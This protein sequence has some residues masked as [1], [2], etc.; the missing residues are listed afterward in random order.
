MKILSLSNLS[1]DNLSIK[2]SI[3][4]GFHCLFLP[5]ALIFLPSLTV[6]SFS[7]ELIHQLLLIVIIP[8]SVIAM[9]L[10]CRKHKNYNVFMY[11]VLGI[12]F[13]FISAFWGHDLFGEFGEKLATLVGSSIIAFGH[14][15]NQSLCKDNCH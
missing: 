2:L 13:L 10:G 9:F 7:E 5:L 14:V 12:S 6:F 8:I 3:F 11:G 4:C 15:K 1:L